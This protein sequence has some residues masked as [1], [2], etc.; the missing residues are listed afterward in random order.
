M[1]TVV[2]VGHY[3]DKKKIAG[4][5]T[6]VYKVIRTTVK[7]TQLMTAKKEKKFRN[8]EGKPLSRS[9]PARLY[10]EDLEALEKYS[11]LGLEMGDIIRR[12]VNKSLPSVIEDIAEEMKRIAPDS[13]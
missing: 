9:V 5:I 13:N 11:Q 10:E 8:R 1:S 3:P 2:Y 7:P 6:F 4:E 12:C